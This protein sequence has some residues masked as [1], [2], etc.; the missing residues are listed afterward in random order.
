[1]FRAEQLAGSERLRVWRLYLRSARNIFKVQFVSI[2]QT[3][4]RLRQA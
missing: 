1:M 2:Y 3:L 4:A